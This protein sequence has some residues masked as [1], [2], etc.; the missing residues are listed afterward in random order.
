VVEL[1]RPVYPDY[2][3]VPNLFEDAPAGRARRLEL[4]RATWQIRGE[5]RLDYQNAPDFPALDP[6][7]HQRPYDD[8]ALLGIA[9]Y[10]RPGA[11][12]FNQIA[13]LRWSRPA[14]V[15]LWQAPEGCYLGGEPIF[16]ED[17]QGRGLRICQMFDAERRK[18]FFLIFAADAVS[19]GPIVRLGLK[20]PMPPGFHAAFAPG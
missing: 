19:A 4:A 15:D 5:K 13:H 7:L 11:K 1:E 3:V 12:L 16:L 20:S 17:R 2:Q 8:F 18:S 9:D 6:K 10:A 14:E